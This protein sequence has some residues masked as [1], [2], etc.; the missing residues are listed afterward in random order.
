MKPK[1]K[2]NIESKKK[3]TDKE[4]LS[5][6]PYVNFIDIT[7][8]W[9]QIAKDKI[10][11]STVI[12]INKVGIEFDYKGNKY[13]IDGVRGQKGI[14]VWNDFDEEELNFGN[15]LRVTFNE[16]VK[17]FPVIR[18][19][20]QGVKTPDFVFKEE[21]W[22]LKTLTSSNYLSL[23]ENIVDKEEQ[24]HNFMFDLSESSMEYNDFIKG[25]EIIFFRDKT[26]FVEKVLIKKNGT[27]YI[28]KKA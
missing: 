19:K 10:S 15:W 25:V 3:D 18:R 28:F 16:N 8:E 4:N 26:A 11:N 5:S 7:D 1:L 9:K 12:I 27:F 20:Y 14:N 22:D 24:S 17:M 23:W 13:T 6:T 21:Y 2:L